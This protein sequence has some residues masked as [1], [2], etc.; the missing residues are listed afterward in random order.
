[1]SVIDPSLLLPAL[2]LALATHMAWRA[3]RRA[4]SAVAQEHLARTM[5]DHSPQAVGL[6]S[7]DGMVLRLN[8]AARQWMVP[9]ETAFQPLWAL[10]A[11]RNAPDDAAA[12]RQANNRSTANRPARSRR[13]GRQH[14]RIE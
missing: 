7:V 6:L 11:W 5:L 3:H 2:G 14:V 12:L 13:H 8:R 1:M 10:P 4:A 9:G